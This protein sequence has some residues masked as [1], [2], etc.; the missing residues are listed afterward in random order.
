LRLADAN[1]VVRSSEVACAA[2]CCFYG[3]GISASLWCKTDYLCFLYIQASLLDVIK[4]EV[5]DL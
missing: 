5:A 1:S 2:R 3:T 4:V